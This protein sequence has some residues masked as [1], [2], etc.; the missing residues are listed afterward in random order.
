M[1][2][3]P[4]TLLLAKTF[5]WLWLDRSGVLTARGPVLPDAVCSPAPRSRPFPWI[6][7]KPFRS[8]LWRPSL[9]DWLVTQP[10]A[11]QGADRWSTALYAAN[12]W[13]SRPNQNGP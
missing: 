8:R 6:P 12:G 10:V 2:S 7:S 4:V 1:S 11:I 9:C 5:T 13:A 3:V